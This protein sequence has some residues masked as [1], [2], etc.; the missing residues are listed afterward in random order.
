MYPRIH[1]ITQITGARK[2][3]PPQSLE[4]PIRGGQGGG[5][6]GGTASGLQLRIPASYSDDQLT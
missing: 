5:W 4:T 2:Q 3:G 1:Y 6:V